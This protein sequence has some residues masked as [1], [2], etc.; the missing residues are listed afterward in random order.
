MNAAIDLAAEISE[1]LTWGEICARYPDQRVCLVEIDR[2]QPHGFAFRTARVV[3]Y[4][5]TP[6]EALDRARPWRNRYEQIGHYFTGRIIPPLPHIPRLVMTD[7]VRESL[8]DR[9]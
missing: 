5:K 7:E 1:P 4:G 6:R 3:G 9:R 8:R 2:P